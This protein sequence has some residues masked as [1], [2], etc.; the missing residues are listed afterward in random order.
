MNKDSPSWYVS[1]L[2]RAIA[3]IKTEIANGKL[4][5]FKC[6][7]HAMPHIS[8]KTKPPAIAKAAD[9]S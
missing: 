6:R 4:F 5:I 1:A 8:S 2:P 3:Q 7:D 9:T